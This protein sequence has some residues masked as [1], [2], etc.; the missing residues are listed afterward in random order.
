[1]AT[2]P[3]ATPMMRGCFHRG[4]AAGESCGAASG[5]HSGRGSTCGGLASAGGGGASDFAGVASAAAPRPI[6]AAEDH[7]FLVALKKFSGSAGIAAVSY[8]HLD[9]YKRQLLES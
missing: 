7:F 4:S 2:I 5:R 9:V 8:T 1:M 3:T 6:A